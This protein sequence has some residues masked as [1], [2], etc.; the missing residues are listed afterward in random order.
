VKNI[1]RLFVAAAVLFVAAGSTTNIIPQCPANVP[2]C[3]AVQNASE[4]PAAADAG[5]NVI[6]QCPVNVPTC[7]P[8]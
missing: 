3:Q 2:T 6:P 7:Q 4:T 8:A 5:T 1:T